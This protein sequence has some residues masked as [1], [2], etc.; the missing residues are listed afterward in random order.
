MAPTATPGLLRHPTLCP[1]KFQGLS[2]SNVSPL[3]DYLP[4]HTLCKSI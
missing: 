4:Y 3:L 1:E 2:L